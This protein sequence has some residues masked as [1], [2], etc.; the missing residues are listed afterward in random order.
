MKVIAIVRESQLVYIPKDES[1][2]NSKD[3]Q[4]DYPPEYSVSIPLGTLREKAMRESFRSRGVTGL[5]TSPSSC[6]DV[7]W[8]PRNLKVTLRNFLLGKLLNVVLLR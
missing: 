6:T 7:M 1:P 4:W 8:I 2:A 3:L 5:L